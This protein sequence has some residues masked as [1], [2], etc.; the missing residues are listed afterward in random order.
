MRIRKLH[1]AWFCGLLMLLAACGEDEYYY[2]P[3]KLEF[4]TVQAGEDG[5]IEMLI[6]DKGEALPV[7]EDR[8][9][10][11]L[12]PNVSGRVMS[13]Y[14]TVAQ[15]D[16]SSAVIY[17]LQPLIVPDPAPADDPIYKDGL[18]HDP[19]EVVSIWLGRDYLNL[20][21]DLKVN[22]GKGHVFGIV[23]DVAELKT[24]GTVNLL[25]YHNANADEQYYNR[26]AYISVPLKGYIDEN[27]PNRKLNIKFEYYT[28]GK[29][30]VAVKSEKYSESGFEYIP[31]KN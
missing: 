29:D 5:R 8:T 12:S 24:T 1:I 10:S 4:V 2:P 31:G 27:H 17:S 15:G 9:K 11:S 26:R 13:N 23:E 25:L 3:V 30:G 20:I 18:K 7:A 22:T 21:L 6:P 19:V 14:E 16:K 28:Y